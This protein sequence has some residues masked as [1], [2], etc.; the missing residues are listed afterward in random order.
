MRSL[1]PEPPFLSKKDLVKLE[2]I[3]RSKME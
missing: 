3:V 2:A 1:I